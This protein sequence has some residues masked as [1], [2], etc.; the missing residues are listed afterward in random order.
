[1]KRICFFI[2]DINKTGG[3]E[4][5]TSVIAS[6][7]QQLGY[8]VHI[9]NFQ[10]GD[11][12]FFKLTDGIK[13]DRLF[14][15]AGSAMFRLPIAVVKLRRY[16]LEHR[17]D[18]LIDVESMISLYALPAVI[19]LRV[20][21]ICWEHFNYKVDLGKFGRRLARK[22][23][24]F[25]ADDIVTLTERDKQF[26]LASTKCRATVTA[27]ANPVTI[28]TTSDELSPF[29]EKIFLAVGRLTYQKGFDLLLQAWASITHLAPDWRLRIIGDG[30]DKSLL[31]K[32]SRDL[33]IEESVEL[34]SKTN[35]ISIH[36]QQA[37]FFLMSSR[38]EGLPLVLIEAQAYGLP[39]ISFDCDTGPSEIV[40]DTETG[41]LCE[42][43]NISALAEKAI[44]AISVFENNT[45]YSYMSQRS[46]E[47]SK[48]FLITPIVNQWVGLFK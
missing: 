35:N 27:I 28:T 38:F 18:V 42:E 17:I 48:K 1:M 23:S 5:V 8:E 43:Q 39:I 24:A 13:V 26:W 11:K 2:G 47:N 37:A 15:S 30:E 6:E 46:R 22:L 29:K 21:H 25:F 12:P 34:V 3:T 36:Y 10:C 14:T 44:D 32:L 19:G 41:W 4:R 33:N 45:M 7:L 20:Q 9:L 40:C 16:L 31:E